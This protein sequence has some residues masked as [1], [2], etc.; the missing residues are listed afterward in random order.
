MFRF[1]RASIFSS[2]GQRGLQVLAIVFCATVGVPLQAETF[3]TTPPSSEYAAYR[4]NWFLRPPIWDAKQ[5]KW[6]YTVVLSAGM[7]S[8]GIPPFQALYAGVSGANAYANVDPVTSDSATWPFALAP[9]TI[10]ELGQGTFGGDGHHA[11]LPTY[12]LIVPGDPSSDSTLDTAKKNDTKAQSVKVKPSGPSCG[13]AVANAHAMLCSLNL[14]D[15]PLGYAPPIGPRIDFTLTYNQREASQPASFDYSNL[16]NKWLHNW[17]SFVEESTVA[18]TPPWPGSFTYVQP[19]PATPNDPNSGVWVAIPGNLG[20]SAMAVVVRL[21]GGGTDDYGQSAPFATGEGPS[22]PCTF[23]NSN[24]NHALLVKVG[25]GSYEQRN[26]DGSKLVY[27]LPQPG[28]SR[29][30]L[31]QIVDA[32]GNSVTLAYDGSIRLTSITD[33]MGKVTTL[34]YDLAADSLKIT[35]VTDPFG[36]TSRFDYN[37]SGQ[38]IKI[39]DAIGLTSQFTYQGDFINTLTTPYGT[40]TFAFGESGNDRWLTLTDPQGGIERV[41]YHGQLASLSNLGVLP[42]SPMLTSSDDDQLRYTLYWDKKAM[43][44]KPG[45]PSSAHLFH[46]LHSLHGNTSAMLMDEKRPF[47]NRVVYNYEGQTDPNYEGTS[48]RRVRVGRVLDDGTSQISKFSYDT[49]GNVSQAIDPLG[50]QTNFTYD[51]TSGID[52]LEVDQKTG[53]STVDVLA[54]F[55]YNSQHL[56]LTSTDAAGQVTTFT[57]NSAGQL[58]TVTNAKSEPTTLWY[59]S[60]GQV[61]NPTLDS[62]ATGYLVQVDGAISGATTKFFYDSSGRPRTVTDSD[63]YAVTTDYDAFDRP[64]AVT[65]PDGT[66]EHMT[67]DRLDVATTTDRRGRVTKMAYNP[68]RQLV[69]VTDP[70]ARVTQY[71]WCKCGALVGLLDPMGQLTKWTYDVQGRMTAKQYADNSKIIYA[72][73]NTTSR[74]KSVTDAKGQVTNYQYFGDDAL[75]QVSYTNATVA[76][77]SVS[78]T[79]DALYP[80]VLTMTDGVGTTTYAYN[81]VPTSP[82]LGAGRLASIDGPFANDTITYAYDELGRVLT[83]AINGAANTSTAVYDALGR[84]TSATNPLGSFTYAYVNTTGRLDH[85]LYPNG[86]RTNYSYFNNAGDQRLQQIQNLKPD[87]SNLST[88]THTYDAEGIIQ[89]WAKQFDAAAALTSAFTYDAAD[90]LTGATVPSAPSVEKN[91]VYRYSKA[92]NRTSEQIDNAVT[93]ATHNVLNQITGLSPSGPIRFEGTIDKPANVT[94]NGL[95]ATV[96]ATNKFSADIPLAPG[97][98]TVAVAATDG[99]GT[100]TTKSYQL[101]VAA[102]S[103]RTPVYDAAGNLLDN[104]A[105]QTYQWDA[106]SRLVKITQASGVTDFVYDGVGRRV[107]EKFNGT[108][109]KQ[110][111]WCDGAQPCEE[112]DANNAVTKRFYATGQQ[113]GGATYYYSMDHLGSVREMTD[114]SGSIRARYDYDSFGR[115]TKISGD[116]EAD[117]G[118]TGFYRHQSSGLSLTFYRAYDP[119]LGIW[120]SR[121]PI[122]EEGGINLYGYV[123]NNPF[124]GIDL[125]GLWRRDVHERAPGQAYGTYTWAVQVGFPTSAAR[126]IG[127]ADIGTDDVTTTSPFPWPWIPNANIQGRSRHFKIPVS[128][129]TD[130]R[131]AWAARELANAVSLWKAGNCSDAYDSL[132]RGLHSLQDKYAHGNWDNENNPNTPHPLWWDDWQRRPELHAAVEQATKDYLRQFI[133]QIRAK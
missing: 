95:P 122:E 131:D 22:L 47:E 12:P 85:V 93:A 49:F 90:Q 18:I 58:R 104:G 43:M 87:T 111:V 103:T 81:P 59:H 41:E 55:T 57:Y 78:F 113:N 20:T 94:V 30:F 61:A 65:F 127:A 112:R 5:H 34:S 100:T 89:S 62:A 51:T 6:Q 96:D 118:F 8:G 117:F 19:N 108:L 39:T 31:T 2:Y 126:A 121:D 40:S 48:P 10:T 69:K 44:E 71:D 97:T 82:T 91:Y 79:Y 102:G 119:A 109:I 64:T 106:A 56:P 110:W 11:I 60:T 14:M 83:R 38:L 92:G 123:D 52:L 77:P 80:R 29:Y 21:P 84:V 120:L 105:G 75:K 63:G 27:G 128:G 37:A 98:Q 115:S 72:Y 9:N 124:N 42:A 70:L 13:M 28:T 16:G 54:K 25:S 23:T 33:A 46:W 17:M 35:K 132:G 24:D 45:D 129:P 50:R 107:Q 86:Q 7:I 114:T 26:P 1:W 88:F 32:F 125:L 99:N 36:R 101:A 3:T 68:I 133:Q 130:S 67:Y 116:L 73:E 15:T 53:A 66:A 4:G 74:L 76:T